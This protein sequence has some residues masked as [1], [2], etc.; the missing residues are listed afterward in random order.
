LPDFVHFDQLGQQTKK[1]KKLELCIS[2]NG[3][4][5][6]IQQLPSEEKTSLF[7]LMDAFLRDPKARKVF[8]G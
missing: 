1:N 7:A 8:C 4:I 2:P 6:A 3:R 5:N